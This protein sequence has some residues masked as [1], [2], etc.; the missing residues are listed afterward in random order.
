MCPPGKNWDLSAA[1]NDY[2]ELRQVHTA[3]L[4]Q[5]FNE[6][7]YYK[8]PETRDTPTHVSKI[9]RPCAQKQEDNAQGSQ[10]TLWPSPRSEGIF[11]FHLSVCFPLV[12][13]LFIS[14]SLSEKR[15]SRGI[16]HASSA[17]VSLA[18]L[19]VASECTSEQF[20]LEMPIY[21]FQLPDLSVYSEDFR[22]FIERDLIEQ[23]TMMALEQ[24]GEYCRMLYIHLKS[25][26]SY[27]YGIRPFPHILSLVRIKC[28]S[29]KAV[30]VRKCSESQWSRQM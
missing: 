6:G 19:Q 28:S 14:L 20:P 27:W 26:C 10:A 4:P 15:L 13:S 3:N 30:A 2:E 22:S 5:V 24:A 25:F 1:L 17:I 7:R 23:S 29:N 21:T 16:S 8:Q 9:D 11:F 18:R 12:P